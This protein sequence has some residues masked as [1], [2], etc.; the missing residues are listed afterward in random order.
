[1]RHDVRDVQ[2]ERSIFVFLDE[3]DREIGEPPRET[4]LVRILLDDPRILDPWQGRNILHHGMVAAVVIRVWNANEVIEPVPGR[5]ELGA[6]PEVPLSVHGG[7]VT[8]SSADLRQQQ[9]AVRDPLVAGMVERPGEPHSLSVA[10]GHE[11]RAGRG[12][13]R[14]RDIEVGEPHPFLR[15]AVEMRRANIFR[16]EAADIPVPQ[17]VREQQHDI[18]RRRNQPP[19][20]RRS[21]RQQHRQHRDCHHGC[22]CQLTTDFADGHG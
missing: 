18:R 4:A 1:M 10:A 21:Q 6:V 20:V 5:V 8:S 22:E 7:C 2:K 12:A 3:R 16:A 14:L 9:L 15:H 17:V 13:D 11:R 19:R